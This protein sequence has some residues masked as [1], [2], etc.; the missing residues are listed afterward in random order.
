MEHTKSRLVDLSVMP[1][2]GII[3]GLGDSDF[4]DME[5]LDADDSILTDIKGRAAAR[6]IVQLVKYNDF[7]NL[8]MR[9]LALSV[10]DELPD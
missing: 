5:V 1:F 2:S 6:D 4:S 8:G 3:V 10:L 7:K 9:E